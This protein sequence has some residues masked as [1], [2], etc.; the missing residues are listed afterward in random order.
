VSADPL[1]VTQNAPAAA[2]LTPIFVELL[3]FSN[4]AF[5]CTSAYFLGSFHVLTACILFS[6]TLLFSFC[7]EGCAGHC[8]VP[9]L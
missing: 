7:V 9:F 1:Q 5:L 3:A 4:Q 6:I 2:A 8:F